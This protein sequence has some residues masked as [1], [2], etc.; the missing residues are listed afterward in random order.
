MKQN[1]NVPIQHK[2]IYTYRSPT[3]RLEFNSEY[4]C[5]T[6]QNIA[7][8]V[9]PNSALHFSN[10]TKKDYLVTIKMH[11]VWIWI[12]NSYMEF[13]TFPDKIEKELMNIFRSPKNYANAQQASY[14]WVI[15]C[16]YR[17]CQKRFRIEVYLIWKPL[18]FLVGQRIWR[19]SG[20]ACWRLQPVR[21]GWTHPRP[22]QG[23]CQFPPHPP[24]CQQTGLVTE[25]YLGK[26]CLFA[27]N[28]L[29]EAW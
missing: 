19:W 22:W 24:H 13:S 14:I 12:Y 10:A 20:A 9:R 8:P 28:E 15:N 17:N 25:F 1:K 5:V 4:I 7:L 3:W 16:K 18:W 6:W 29:K 23:P 21:P 11:V 27:F 2:I 26:N